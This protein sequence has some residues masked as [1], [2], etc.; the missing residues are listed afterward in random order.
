ML[1]RAGRCRWKGVT[2]LCYQRSTSPKRPSSVSVKGIIQCLWRSF[3]VAEG[4]VA[5]L[6]KKWPFGVVEGCLAVR[7][8]KGHTVLS[9]FGVPFDEGCASAGCLRGVG[10]VPSAPKASTVKPSQLVTVLFMLFSFSETVI[11][12]FFGFVLLVCRGFC[13][14]RPTLPM[15]PSLHF[16]WQA[17]VLWSHTRIVDAPD[18]SA[19]SLSEGFGSSAANQPSQ[20]GLNAKCIHQ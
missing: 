6:K 18:V 9:K 16:M 12:Y 3:S 20:G 8:I 7:V 15:L 11:I 19:K 10:P 5:S 2:G 1:S 14:P 13:R 17:I 4:R